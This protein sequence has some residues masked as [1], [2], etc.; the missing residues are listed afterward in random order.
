MLWPSVRQAIT[1][2]C[3]SGIWD[4]PTTS[5]RRTRAALQDDNAHNWNASYPSANFDDTLVAGVRKGDVLTRKQDGAVYEI[6]RVV[7]NGFGRTTLQLSRRR[8]ALH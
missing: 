5:R 4:G 8:Q 2:I 3:W 1:A 7:P 6:V